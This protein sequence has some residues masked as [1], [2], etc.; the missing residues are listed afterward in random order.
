MDTRELRQLITKEFGAALEHATP[1]NVREFLDRMELGVP[2]PGSTGRIILEEKAA[3]YEGI[4]KD[5][6]VRVLDMPRD[7]AVALLWLLAFDLSFSAIELQHED[8]LMSLF[9]EL[10]ES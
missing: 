7:E 10:E 5:F 8:K 3:S 9:K 1:A 2:G 6:F 4:L